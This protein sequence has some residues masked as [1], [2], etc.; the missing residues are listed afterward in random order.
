MRTIPLSA[1][2]SQTLKITLGTQ[3]CQIN[4]YTLTTG[5]Y[6]DLLVDGSAVITGA[7]CHDRCR[8]VRE[9]YLGFTGDLS[10]IDTQ[11]LD[12]PVYSGLGDRYQLLY[13]EPSD[14]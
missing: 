13:L 6:L 5:L 4:V 12:D 10:F 8:L 9:A 3:N 11:G 1:K 14:L 2:P 7:L